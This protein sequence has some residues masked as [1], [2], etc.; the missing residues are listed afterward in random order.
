VD[1]YLLQRVGGNV[2]HNTTELILTWKNGQTN[3]SSTNAK[4]GVHKASGKMHTSRL[5]GKCSK[6]GPVQ[7]T[8]Q[9]KKAPTRKKGV[10]VVLKWINTIT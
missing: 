8:L 9:Y 10:S 3:L 4:P 7:T 5:C 2:A 6:Q 1:G